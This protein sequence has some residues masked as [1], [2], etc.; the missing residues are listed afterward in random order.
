MRVFLPDNVVDEAD[1]EDN[2]RDWNEV[3]KTSTS[4]LD[5]ARALPLCL[6]VGITFKQT[7]NQTVNT[8]PCQISKL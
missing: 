8:T 2:Y 6:L 1:G 7:E 5:R 4:L 3:D